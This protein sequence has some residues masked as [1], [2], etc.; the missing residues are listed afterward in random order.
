VTSARKDEDA[1]MLSY[2]A[3]RP[4]GNSAVVTPPPEIDATNAE[5]LQDELN[6][7]L[8]RGMTTVIVDMTRTTFCDSAGSR[9]LLV[10]HQRASGMNADLRIVITQQAVRRVFELL[11]LD[12]IIH[13]YASLAAAESEPAENALHI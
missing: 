2:S 3:H 10:A 5:E 12:E 4:D 7:V 6:A 11:G 9:A 8:D 13:V 1:N